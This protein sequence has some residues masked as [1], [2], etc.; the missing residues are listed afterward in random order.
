MIFILTLTRGAP[1]FPVLIIALVPFRLLV[2]KKWWPREVLRFVDAWA[3]HEGTPEDDEDTAAK[4]GR[5]AQEALTEDCVSVGRTPLEETGAQRRSSIA[6]TGS[7]SEQ[8]T[9]S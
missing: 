2:M 8:Y 5:A 1:A 9:G 3:C 7:V 6:G 4:D